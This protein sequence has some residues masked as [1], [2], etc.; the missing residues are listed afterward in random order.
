MR[1][2]EGVVFARACEDVWGGEGEYFAAGEDVDFQEE[3]LDS[4]RV[5]GDL[6]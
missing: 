2:G 3:L 4:G 1:E 5:D 6:G